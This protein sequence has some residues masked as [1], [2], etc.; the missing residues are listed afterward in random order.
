MFLKIT[1]NGATAGSLGTGEFAIINTS[2]ILNFDFDTSGRINRI[3]F[4]NASTNPTGSDTNIG[5][6]AGNTG[7]FLVE[8]FERWGERPVATNA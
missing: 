1:N 6:L 3:Q 7:T 4:L 8:V 5:A 2:N